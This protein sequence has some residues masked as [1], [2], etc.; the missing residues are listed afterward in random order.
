MFTTLVDDVGFTEGPVLAQD[1]ALYVTSI[2]R[3]A[4][5]RISDHKAD[6]F[7]ETGGGANGLTEG[8]DGIFYLAQN[9]GSW[10][11]LNKVKAS[12]GVQRIMP[13]GTVDRIGPA[14]KSPNDLAFGPDGWLYVT[15]PTRK[16]ER[17]DSRLWRVDIETGDSELLIECDWYTNGIGFGADDGWIYV[18]D[19]K[20][21]RIVRLPI[22]SR[23]SRHLET[24]IQMS[25]NHP[26]GFGFDLQG[27]IVIACP[28]D[29]KT[30]GNIQ[31]WSLSGE[32]VETIRPGSSR[33]YTNIVLGA[34]GMAYVT[35]SDGGRVLAGN[36]GRPGL[37]LHPFR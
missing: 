9:G 30:P 37:A 20:N 13:D 27:N 22:G 19:T 33:Y 31:I 8:R 25:E 35:D 6:M 3:G 34:D 23:D 10:P 5:Y 7:A 16:P 12:P 17:D 18:A 24:V 1:G 28:G 26:D 11:A 21:A 15:D 2:D 29:E 36:L 4:V 14:M 32:H